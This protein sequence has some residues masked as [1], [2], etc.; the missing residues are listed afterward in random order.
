MILD[1]KLVS[2]AM[3]IFKMQRDLPIRFLND[4]IRRLIDF[5]KLTEDTAS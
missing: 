5:A 1:S 2:E 3:Y 4:T